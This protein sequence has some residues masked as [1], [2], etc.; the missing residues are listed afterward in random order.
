MTETSLI[1]SVI[2]SI[3]SP[4]RHIL[5]FNDQESTC[6]GSHYYQCPKVTYNSFPHQ[7]KRFVVYGESHLQAKTL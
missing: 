5:L 2:W 7:K 3:L 1:M 6:V 4:Y